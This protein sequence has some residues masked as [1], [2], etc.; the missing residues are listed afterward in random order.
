MPFYSLALLSAR[1]EAI[2]DTSD[3]IARGMPA[4]DAS[5]G[6]ASGIRSRLRFH[7]PL[8]RHTITYGDP[9]FPIDPASAPSAGW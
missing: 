7:G 6:S 3:E 8:I 4:A 1:G 5:T 9:R 2:V